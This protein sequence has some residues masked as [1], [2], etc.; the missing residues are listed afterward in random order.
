M[1]ILVDEEGGVNELEEET[2]VQP[3]YSLQS[4]VGVAKTSGAE[5]EM[6][7]VVRVR[8]KYNVSVAPSNVTPTPI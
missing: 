3:A 4:N 2:Y 1:T 7:E 6:V 8:A 5:G